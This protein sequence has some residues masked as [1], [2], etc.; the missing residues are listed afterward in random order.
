MQIDFLGEPTTGNLHLV[1]R[2]ASEGLANVLG[3]KHFDDIFSVPYREL[4]QNQQVVTLL[5]LID[6][7]AI[8]QM[9]LILIRQRHACRSCSGR[10]VFLPRPI[11]RAWRTEQF[12][13]A[14]L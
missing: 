9:I 5:S 7:N 13:A 1:Q 6:C 10:W 4:R 2:V 8:G 3:L 12:T 14:E 11:R